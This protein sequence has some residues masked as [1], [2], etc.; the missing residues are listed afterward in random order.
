MAEMPRD[1]LA[2][3]FSISRQQNGPI[4]RLISCLQTIVVFKPNMLAPCPQQT[5]WDHAEC[6]SFIVLSWDLAFLFCWVAFYWCF[7]ILHHYTARYPV[8]AQY[9]HRCCQFGHLLY[10]TTVRAEYFLHTTTFLFWKHCLQCLSTNSLET[11]QS[12]VSL[13]PCF[14]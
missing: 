3:C 12:D 6:Y 4:I 8:F 11:F 1:V 13:A 2:R 7:F 5:N 10:S 14:M 9:Y